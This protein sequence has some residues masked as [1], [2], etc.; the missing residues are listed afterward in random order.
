MGEFTVVAVLICI[1]GALGIFGNLNI[2]F[3]AF[4]M[5]PRHKSSLLIGILGLSDLFCILAE[6]QNATRFFLGVQSYQREC[7]WAI[8]SYLVMVDVQSTLMTALAFDRLLAFCMP[9]M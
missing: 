3:V 9:F 5:K 8:S 7:F 2:L 1:I 6:L 4:R